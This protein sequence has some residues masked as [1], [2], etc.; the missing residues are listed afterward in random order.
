[1]AEPTVIRCPACGRTNRVR[2]DATGVPFCGVCGKPLP[3][4]VEADQQSFRAIVE[5]SPLPVLVD[6]WAPWCGPCRIVSP[7]VEQL[8]VELAGRLKVAKVNTDNAPELGGR[9]NVFSIPTLMLMEQG[10]ERDRVVGAQG[11]APLRRWL[12]SRLGT[13]S[14]TT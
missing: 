9:F 10:R 13:S 11:P 2:P 5:E 4:I 12:E 14:P 3:W 1:M 7:A 8:G 6:F